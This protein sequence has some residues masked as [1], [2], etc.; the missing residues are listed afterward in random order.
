L[1]DQVQYQNIDQVTEGMGDWIEQKK[2][3]RFW[4]KQ[5]EMGGY[6]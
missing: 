1:E 2:W 6:D 3:V 4:I 5:R